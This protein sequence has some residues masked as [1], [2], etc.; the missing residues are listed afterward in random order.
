MKESSKY[1]SE[2]RNDYFRNICCCSC[3]H[4]CICTTDATVHNLA[5]MTTFFHRISVHFM[6][7][8]LEMADADIT[9]TEEDVLNLAEEDDLCAA[10]ELLEKLGIDDDDIDDIEDTRQAQFKLWQLLG[11]RQAEREGGSPSFQSATAYVS[12]YIIMMCKKRNQSIVTV[13]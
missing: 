8:H 3:N 13:C 4:Q 11:R 5:I 7:W 9:L 6:S 1:W 10:V 12:V 2:C